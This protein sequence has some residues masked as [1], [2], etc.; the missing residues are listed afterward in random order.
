MRAS[1][2]ATSMPRFSPRPDEQQGPA[3]GNANEILCVSSWLLCGSALSV[4]SR[5]VLVVFEDDDAPLVREEPEHDDRRSSLDLDVDRVVHV[6]TDDQGSSTD[7][8]EQHE[9]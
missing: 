4:G 9:R 2:V 6:G 5:S 8:R 7:V 3:G 1:C